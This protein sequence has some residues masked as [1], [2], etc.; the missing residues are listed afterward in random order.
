[1]SG[2]YTVIIAPE[3]VIEVSEIAMW[4]NENR[5][6]APRLF[7]TELDRAVLRLAER[8][9]V[10]PKVRVR[11]RLGL[12]V[13]ALQRTGYLVFYQLDPGEKQVVVVRVRRGHRRPIHRR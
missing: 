12:R 11:G 10:G 4:W 9:E 8:P 13:L 7:Q 2:A 1:M 3:A 6:A 5:P